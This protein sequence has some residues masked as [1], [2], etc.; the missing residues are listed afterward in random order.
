MDTEKALRQSEERYRVLV[1]TMPQGVVECDLSGMITFSSAAHDRMKG[2]PPGAFLGMKIWECA[3]QTEQDRLRDFFAR[4]VREQP[5]PSPLILPMQRADDTEFSARIDW[6]YQRDGQGRIT[7]FV[8][9]MTDLTGQALA[10][11]S[12]DYKQAESQRIQQAVERERTEILRQFVQEAASHDFRTPLAIMKTSLYLLGRTTD[13][14]RHNH[15]LG[16]LETQLDHLISLIESLLA[17]ADLERTDEDL[18][19]APVDINQ[20][21]RE[22]LMEKQIISTLKDHKIDFVP[23]MNLPPV[24][25]NGDELERALFQIIR[26][27]VNYTP[28]QGYIRVETSLCQDQVAIEVTDTG[29]GISAHDLPK[30]FNPFYKADKARQLGDNGMG[31]GLTIARN[32]VEAHRGRID[33]E[34]QLGEGSTFRICLPV[35]IASD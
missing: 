3:A 31:L 24:L 32:I 1:E 23:G 28:G 6:N 15:Y 21:I 16:Q 34:S 11:E 17:M 12:L 7:G 20:L 29:I 30:I 5:V 27:A 8:A 2:C 14:A 25:A 9:V 18:T 35:R 19:L 4:A 13:P 33:V 26:N 10:D 22:L